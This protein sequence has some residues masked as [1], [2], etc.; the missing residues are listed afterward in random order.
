M[1]ND[2]SVVSVFGATGLIGQNVVRML[3]SEGYRIRIFARDL[4]KS[5]N[6]FPEIS[7]H[8]LWNYANEGWKPSLVGTGAVINFSGA[9]IFRKWKGDYRKEIWNSRVEATRQIVDAI[10]KL[11]QKPSILINGSAA[12]IYGYDSFDDSDVA[13]SSPPGKDFWGDLVSAWEGEANKAEN[14]GTRVVNIRTTVVLDRESGALPQLVSVFRKG[15]GGPISP[16]NQWFPWIHIEDEVGLV[17]FAMENDTVSGPINAGSPEVPRMEDFAHTLGEVM[18]KQSRVKIPLT[19]IR[20]MMG[21]VSNV[22]AKGK[23][24][25]PARAL[26]LGY[27]FKFVKLR[28]ALEDLLGH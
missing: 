19:V 20:L 14:F 21:E 24:V 26:E 12:G 17:M 4:S 22:L 16:G 13:E 6:L 10:S 8:V 7:D 28:D 15:I 27:R 5:R 25:V 18:H 3:H 9:P 23:K 11:E 1:E 2:S